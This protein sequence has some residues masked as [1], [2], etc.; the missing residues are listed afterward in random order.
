MGDISRH[1]SR[2]KLGFNALKTL[3]PIVNW[4]VGKHLNWSSTCM[5]G[6]VD[7]EKCTLVSRDSLWMAALDVPLLQ[8]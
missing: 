6:G 7:L 2:N 3:E 4:L 1:Q 8:G 5:T